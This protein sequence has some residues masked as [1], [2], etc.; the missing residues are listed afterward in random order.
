M[1]SI[2]SRDDSKALVLAALEVANALDD[3]DADALL[4][5]DIIEY[6]LVLWSGCFSLA[7]WMFCCSGRSI[8]CFPCLLVVFASGIWSW[9]YRCH[10]GACMEEASLC[11]R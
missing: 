11:E 2:Q 7:V 9:M 5:L 1:D 8:L 6:Q 10:P 3:D 4:F